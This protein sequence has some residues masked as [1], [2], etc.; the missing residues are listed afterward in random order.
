VS[1]DLAAIAGVDTP[2]RLLIGGQWSAGQRGVLP[3]INPAT[4]EPIAE[5]ADA[6]VPDAMDAVSAAAAA[7]PGWAARAPRERGE[8]LRRAYELMIERAEPLARL[9]VAENG[10]AL[11]DARGE[12]TYAAEFFRW[13]AEEAVRNEGAFTVAPSGANKILVTHQPVGVSVLITPWNFPAAMA[14]R[15][16]GPALAAGCTVILKPAKET[17]LTALAVAGILAEAGVPDGVVNV[18]P[19]SQPGPITE[20]MLADP[21][22]RKLSFTGS[23]EVGRMLLKTAADTVTNCSMELGGNAPFLVFEDADIDAAVAGAYLAKMRNGGEACT[24]AN[25]FYVHE[26]VAAEFSAK[27]ARRLAAVRLGPGLEDGVELGPLVN[28][29]TRDKVASLVESATRDGG[30]VILGGEAPKRPGYFYAA[31]VLD[32]VPRGAGIL[33]QEIFGP[34]APIVR[35]TGTDEA[36]ALANGTEYG[37]VS[38]LYSGDLRRS[39]QVAEALEAGMVGINRGVVSDPA[40]PFGGVKQ[41]GIGRE[42]GHDGLLEFTETKYIAVEW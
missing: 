16:I 22:V 8:C 13:Y 6:G 40:A 26:S 20:A 30:R 11:P 42:G 41:S 12:I 7:L 24:A 29:D 33:S 4:E 9:M 28:A 14:T 23:T 10:K 37:L 2:T 31:T 5:V 25:R 32:D 39:L 21:R 34:V 15:K 38:Y 18:L 35:F 27:L 19:T 1:S 17:P 36:I 3:V